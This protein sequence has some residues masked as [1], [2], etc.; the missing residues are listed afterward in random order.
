MTAENIRIAIVGT[1]GMANSHGEA[2]QSMDGVELVGAVDTNPD[3]L[4]TY[5]DK[6]GIANRFTS[7]DDLLAWGE[8]DAVSN[9]TPDQFHYATTLPL[10][11]ANK[12]VLCEKPLATHYAHADEMATLAEQKGVVNMVNLTYRRVDA[13]QMARGIVTD[14][15]LGNLRYFEASYQQSWLTQPAWGEWTT[16]PHW[17][18]RLST[19]HGSK[20]VLGDIGVHI[21]DFLSYATGGTIT[22]IASHLKTFDKAENNQIGEYT[23]D[24]NDSFIML[25]SLDNSTTEG[26]AAT[27]TITATRFASGNLNNLTVNLHGDKGSLMVR[28]FLENSGATKTSLKTC[29]GADNMEHAHWQDIHD[30]GSPPDSNYKK[31]IDAIK[32]GQQGDPDFRRG[33]DLQGIIDKAENM[34]L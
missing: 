34:S 21:L 7:V 10:L 15:Q 5:C 22:P 9:V 12:H 2:Y 27:G 17:L 26:G 3:N 20:G 32:T 25:A 6:F 8:F 13:L 23:L 31:F 18:W 24:A 29:I 1:G 14:G 33:A 16:E 28:E 19:Q 11:K 30:K 4:N